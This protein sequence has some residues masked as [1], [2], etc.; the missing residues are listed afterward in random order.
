MVADD[1]AGDVEPWR[2]SAD[3][4]QVSTEKAEFRCGIVKFPVPCVAPSARIHHDYARS[5]AAELGEE[6][7]FV[8]GERDHAIDGNGRSET[9]GGGIG[10][11]EGVYQQRIAM[12]A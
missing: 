8:H 6:G 4:S 7:A 2:P 5:E 9:A 1:R 3:S 10:R 12:L 11:V